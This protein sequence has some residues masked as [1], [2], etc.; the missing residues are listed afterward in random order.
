MKSLKERLIPPYPLRDGETI[1]TR[2]MFDDWYAQHIELLFA[3]AVEV[4]AMVNDDDGDLI[5]ISTS[6]DTTDEVRGL[7]I[8]VEP[9][10][11]GVTKEEILRCLRNWGQTT[12][13]DRIEKEGIKP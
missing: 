6:L 11:R 8:G 2:A 3:N 12:L 7:L 13:A 9:I 1:M 5:G 10:E 4:Y